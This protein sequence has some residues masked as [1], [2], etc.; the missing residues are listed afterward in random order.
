MLSDSDRAAIRDGHR[1]LHLRHRGYALSVHDTDA[2]VFVTGNGHGGYDDVAGGAR[3]ESET[4]ASRYVHSRVA[5]HIRSE[6]VPAGNGFYR[7]WSDEF[8]T[9]EHEIL[10]TRWHVVVGDESPIVHTLQLGFDDVRAGWRFVEETLAAAGIDIRDTDLIEHRRSD[11]SPYSKAG[12]L[13]GPIDEAMREAIV[14]GERIL[15]LP[16]RSVCYIVHRTS[17]GPLVTNSGVGGYDHYAQAASFRDE[18]RALDYAHEQVAKWIRSDSHRGRDG[19]FH[20]VTLCR[21][22]V[23]VEHEWRRGRWTVVLDAETRPVV[24]FREFQ[25]EALATGWRWVQETVE[26]AGLILEPGELDRHRGSQGDE[27]PVMKAMTDELRAAVAAGQMVMHLPHRDHHLKVHTTSAGVLLTNNALGGFDDH[28]LHLTYPDVP[29]A[30]QA[31]YDRVAHWMR[32]SP[33]ERSWTGDGV[34]IEHDRAVNRWHIAIG[35]EHPVVHTYQY[36]QF[37]S[38][39][40]AAGWRFV[41]QTLAAAGISLDQVPGLADDRAEDLPPQPEPSQDEQQEPAPGGLRALLRRIFSSRS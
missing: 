18:G 31:A 38:N 28:A 17:A 6:I 15:F 29:A 33:G 26:S 10:Y 1:V 41:E 8:V 14:N 25:P 32:N 30:R 9:V 11:L 16:H 4:E 22:H 27:P 5:T 20:T 23:A 39:G 2:G 12:D 24:H 13:F 34:V 21:G 3:F 7:S 37:D 35:A 36:G 19:N 40:P